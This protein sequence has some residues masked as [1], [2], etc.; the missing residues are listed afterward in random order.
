VP[1]LTGAYDELLAAITAVAAFDKAAIKSKTAERRGSPDELSSLEAAVLEISAGRAA[2]AADVEAVLRV[3][4]G[5]TGFAPLPYATVLPC[6]CL[7]VETGRASAALAILSTLGAVAPLAPPSLTSPTWIAAPEWPEGA[8]SVSLLDAIYE[9][10]D[11]IKVQAVTHSF[12]LLENT[13]DANSMH[14]RCQRARVAV[15][16][17]RRRGRRS[18]RETQPEEAPALAA[19]GEADAL[20]D[21]QVPLIFLFSGYRCRV[22]VNRSS[23]WG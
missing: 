19:E 8:L 4:V 15:T 3:A 16:L 5:R 22:L 2:L 9:R 12:V 20:S 23:I 6:L 10:L 14:P 17:K 11:R 7:L 18:A 13:L 21:I 1:L